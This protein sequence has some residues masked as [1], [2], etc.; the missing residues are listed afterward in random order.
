MTGL[1]HALTS[2]DRPIAWL[3]S[4]LNGERARIREWSMV[5]LRADFANPL[6]HLRLADSMGDLGAASG[7]MA[8]A[9]LDVY[10]RARCAPAKRAL[11]VLHSDGPDRGAIL[12][13]EQA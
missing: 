5:E 10:W 13:E 12:I 11:V 6:V 3:V 4:D 8:L 1:A 7:P 2:A 9:L